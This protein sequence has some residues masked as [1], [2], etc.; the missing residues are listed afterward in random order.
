MKRL[1]IVA[2]AAGTAAIA[3]YQAGAAPRPLA[4]VFP[5]GALVFLEAKDFAQLLGEWDRSTVKRDWLSSANY[6]EF[7]RSNLYLK[8]NGFY[9]AYGN[10][11]GFLPDMASLRS[12]AGDESALALYDLKDVQFAYVT[13]ISE[14]RAAQS[15]LW[16]AR[17]SFQTRQAAGISFYTKKSENV[18][19]AFAVSNGY[20]LVCSGEERMAGMLGLL[21]GK[22]TP[23]IANEGWYKNSTNAAG[24]PG[25]LRLAMNLET[26]AGNTY[27]RSYWVQRNVSEV[28]RFVSGVTDIHRTAGEI[29]EKRL[30]LKR[31][32]L[33][34]D[35]AP[36]EALAAGSALTQLA[37]DVAGLYRVWAEPS[38]SDA[39]ALVEGHILNP[40][41]QNMSAPRYAPPEDQGGGTGNEADLETRIDEPP[42]PA[43]GVQNSDGLLKMLAGAQV[44]AMIEVESSKARPA[45]PF[46]ALPCAIGLMGRSA[47][48]ADR[49]K[50]VAGGEWTT[51]AHGAHTL[52]RAGGLSRLTFLAEGPLLIVANDADLLQSMLDHRANAVPSLNADYAAYFRHDRERANY[53]RMMTALDFSQPHGDQS[54]QFFSANIAS[55]SSALRRVNGIEIAERNTADRVEQRVVYRLAP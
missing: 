24:A 20:L 31:V 42:L 11:A 52:Y 8:L 23:N 36:A 34:E 41:A 1:V 48:N 54:P 47:W 5:G 38:T 49:V 40:R 12:L 44:L 18:E 14:S 32:G 15:R 35:L 17:G 6:D 29:E 27:F 50:E 19:L 45:N 26:L 46:I 21:T 4:P 2:V 25:E 30:F 53:G 22:A 3:W 7:Q 55:L 28:R 39:A 37:P 13:R 51:Q 33:E 16:L 10:A 9:K 43:P